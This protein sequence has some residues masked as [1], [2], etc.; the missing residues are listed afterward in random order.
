MLA[1]REISGALAAP[2]RQGG[3]GGEGLLDHVAV[4]LAPAATLPGRGAQVVLHT[5]VGEDALAAGHL[6]HAETGDLV[7][8]QVGDVAAVEDDGAVV[9]LDD[10]A[11]GP[12]QR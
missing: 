8:R 6:G 7:G 2:W 12:Q 9:G 10:T 1:T 3:E 5:E 4:V 11:D